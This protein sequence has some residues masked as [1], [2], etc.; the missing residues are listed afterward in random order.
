MFCHVTLGA[1]LTSV[2]GLALYFNDIY[3]HSPFEGFI[4]CPVKTLA[5]QNNTIVLLGPG[6]TGAF[7]LI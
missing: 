3:A 6:E 2:R 5:L 7:Q 1:D 4:N